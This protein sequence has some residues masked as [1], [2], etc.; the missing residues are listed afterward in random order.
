MKLESNTYLH[1]FTRSNLLNCGQYMFRCSDKSGN[2]S[3]YASVVYT[4][5]YVAV[6]KPK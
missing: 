3:K 1:A 2:Y 6:V 5:D 4:N